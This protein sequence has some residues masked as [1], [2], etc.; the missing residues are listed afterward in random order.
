[1]KDFTETYADTPDETIAAIDAAMFDQFPKTRYITAKM[2]PM[3]SWLF[4][5]I[6]WLV[7]DRVASLL[8]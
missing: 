8:L 1:M 5:R 6:M 2:G 4:C 7:P 3:P